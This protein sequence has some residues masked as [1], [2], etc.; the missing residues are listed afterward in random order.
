RVLD[1]EAAEA[2]LRLLRGVVSDEGT[3]RRAQIPGYV[4]AGK[5][6]TAWQPC[7]AEFGYWC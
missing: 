4:V 5:T 1:A 3:G 6:G 2:V 7:S